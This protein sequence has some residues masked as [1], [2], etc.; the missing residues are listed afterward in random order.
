[1]FQD[2]ASVLFGVD[3][4]Q[5][6]D[7]EAGPDSTTTVWVVT[8]HAGA[9]RC[10]D[11]GTV[12]CR[13]HDRVLTRPRDVAHGLDQSGVCW[14]K[15]RW[16]CTQE[17][18]RRKTFTESVPQVPPRHRIAGR[19]RE[20]ASHEVAERGLTLWV[21][22]IRSHHATCE[23]SWRRPPSRSRLRTRTLS[24]QSRLGSCRRVVSGQGSGAAGGYCSD[25]R[26]R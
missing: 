9:A 18:C 26:I 15:R 4:L 13:P 5:V 3:G 12:S 17:Q 14:V 1:M 2:T 11:C 6:I 23:Y 22:K 10:P 8:D 7:A 25:R 20:L 19:L 16:K 24:P 21:P